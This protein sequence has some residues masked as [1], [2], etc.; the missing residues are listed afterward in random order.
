M[1]P[2]LFD[3]KRVGQPR[4]N[5]IIK[6]LE[7]VWEVLKARE[8]VDVSGELNIEDVMVRNRIARAAI[9]RDF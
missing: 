2:R 3:T 1:L 9:Q 5:W 4:H 8:S 6:G 7:K